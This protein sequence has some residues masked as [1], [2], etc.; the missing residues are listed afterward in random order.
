MRRVGAKFA[1]KD[2]G[3]NSELPRQG[4]AQSEVSDAVQVRCYTVIPEITV[5]SQFQ[6]SRNCASRRMTPRSK[7]A[8]SMLAAA[9]IFGVANLF[10]FLRPVTCW[11]CF[12]PYGTPFTLFQDGGEGGGGGFVLGGVAGGMHW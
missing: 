6:I 1:R 5:V 10:N 2:D 3:G 7:Y 12:F 9:G 11:D 4:H 8:V